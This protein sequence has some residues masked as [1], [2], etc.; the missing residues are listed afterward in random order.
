VIEPPVLV[1]LEQTSLSGV[2]KQVRGDPRLALAYA[3]SGLSHRVVGPLLSRWRPGSVA[4]IHIGSCGSTVVSDL[5]GQHPR[6]YWDG[7]TYGRVIEQ[8]KRHGLSRGQVDFDPV[9][10]VAARQGRSGRRW[11][12]FDLKFSH[13]TEFGLTLEDYLAGLHA[14][15]VTAL[16]GLRRRNYLRRV[17][18][19]INGGRRGRYHHRGEAPLPLEPVMLPLDD[20]VVDLYR[21]SM[22]D[23]FQ[24]WDRLYDQLS[25]L[26]GPSILWL[27]YEEHVA[28]DP[29][30]AYRMVQDH[31]GLEPHTPRVRLSRSNPEPL[32]DLVANLDDVADH[33]AGTPYA[34]M[35]EQ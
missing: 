26:G 27:T 30:V 22:L 7:E 32:G 3:R 4:L 33:L 29:T 14:A 28:D 17:V 31:L 21:S 1:G 19:G 23:H 10:Y 13:V 6:V 8:I 34:W 20:L 16:V 15:G 25:D 24:R 12:G 2:R 5:V 9:A 35:V 11:Y 18:S